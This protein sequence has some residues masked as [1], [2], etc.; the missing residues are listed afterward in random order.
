M[1]PPADPRVRGLMPAAA[2]SIKLVCTPLAGVDGC[3]PQ[4]HFTTWPPSAYSSGQW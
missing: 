1:A 4:L 3:R 2:A